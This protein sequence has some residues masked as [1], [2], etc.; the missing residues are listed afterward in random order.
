[1]ALIIVIILATY[2]YIRHSTSRISALN[3]NMKVHRIFI[4]IAVLLAGSP[5]AGSVPASAGDTG[6][7]VASCR[8]EAPLQAY[9]CLMRA[10]AIVRVR[11]DTKGSVS[12]E[13]TDTRDRVVANGTSE[14][15]EISI[16]TTGLPSGLYVITTGTGDKSR[17]TRIIVL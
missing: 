10:G 14:Q 4:T 7:C 11:L 1:M 2:L 3:D 12:W 8:Y 17:R 5:L 15:S 13:L 16:D 6:G 9:P